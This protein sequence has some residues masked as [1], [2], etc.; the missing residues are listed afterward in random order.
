MK[1]KGVLFAA[2]G[3]GALTHGS[4]RN[5]PGAPGR[6]ALA[7]QQFLQNGRVISLFILR[8]KYERD[9]LLRMHELIEAIERLVCRGLAQFLQILLAKRFPFFRAGVV[10]AAQFV[11]W[12]EVAQPFIGP[13]L[14][15]GEASWPQ[16][17]HQHA[18]AVCG[19]RRFVH[20]FDGYFH[21]ARNQYSIIV[22]RRGRRRITRPGLI[23]N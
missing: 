7:E 11:G 20:S 15:F 21:Q 12:G 3:T 23:C 16:A 19:G 18:I 5:W 10:P 4:G 22:E 13:G 6:L 9:P 14:F 1:L 2:C 17:I 8:G